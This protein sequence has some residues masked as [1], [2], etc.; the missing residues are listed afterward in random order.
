MS[1]QYWNWITYSNSLNRIHYNIGLQ[2]AIR[3]LTTL[4][5]NSYHSRYIWFISVLIEIHNLREILMICSYKWF[6]LLLHLQKRHVSKWDRAASRANTQPSSEYFS[7][8]MLIILVLWFFVCW[9]TCCY[10]WIWWLHQTVNMNR[11][12]MVV[13]E[14]WMRISTRIRNS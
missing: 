5:S 14:V 11:G 4:Q 1:Q 7:I 8:R 10:V 9:I 13:R 6:E 2:V 3:M 12:S